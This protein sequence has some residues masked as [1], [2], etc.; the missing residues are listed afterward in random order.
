MICT[1]GILTL[2]GS[3]LEVTTWEQITA[4][5]TGLRPVYDDIPT[6]IY[7]IK[8]NNGPLLTLDSTMGALVEAQ[9]V[10]ANTPSLLAQYES[11]A[12]LALGKL[13]LD[14]TGIMLQTHLLPWHDIEAVRYDFEAIRDIRYFSRLSIFQR[15]S[16]KAWAVLRS[17]DL[18]S[19]ELAR[20]VIEQIQAKQDEKNSI[21]T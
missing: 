17:R 21:I 19:L 4:I 12:P 11:G 9:Y 7:R 16:G 14:F 3:R 5:K 10:E 1:G 20:K 8:S 13:R 18:P 15:G 2:R 6:I